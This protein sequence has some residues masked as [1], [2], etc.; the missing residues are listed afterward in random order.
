M[1][2]FFHTGDYA[3]THTKITNIFDDHFDE[4]IMHIYFQHWTLSFLKSTNYLI[5][6]FIAYDPLAYDLLFIIQS[7]NEYSKTWENVREETISLILLHLVLI[8]H[9]ITHVAES[10]FHL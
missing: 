3:H 10:L 2:V 1:V 9:K 5:L 8:W 6:F 4:T 7:I